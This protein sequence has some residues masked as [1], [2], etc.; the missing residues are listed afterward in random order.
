MGCVNSIEDKAAA[1]Q[2]RAGQSRQQ[3]FQAE[4]AAAVAEM[5]GGAGT[6]S[7]VEISIKCRSLPNKD[8]FRWG[9]QRHGAG[10]GRC[11]EAW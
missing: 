7:Q 8:T 10:Q 5:L 4:A 9:R 11:V 1:G 2:Q 6:S 3:V